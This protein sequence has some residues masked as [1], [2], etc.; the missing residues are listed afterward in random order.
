MNQ[1][2][3]LVKKSKIKYGALI[4]TERDKY[5]ASR[6]CGDILKLSGCD[7]ILIKTTAPGTAYCTNPP[8]DGTSP[9]ICAP[10]RPEQPE[11]SQ[12][13]YGKGAI[14]NFYP[15]GNQIII[16]PNVITSVSTCVSATLQ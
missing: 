11:F 2:E 15:E 3:N 6:H 4:I 8:T 13:S 14:M 12:V 16:E 10:N 7:K 5:L 1:I 9:Y